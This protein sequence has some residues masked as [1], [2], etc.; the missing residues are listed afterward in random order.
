MDA[1]EEVREYPSRSG[2]VVPALAITGIGAVSR[3]CGA[4]HL[5]TDLPIYLDALLRKEHFH[6]LRR[7]LA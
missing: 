4:S 7:A 3:A 2:V 1:D 5:P 6:R